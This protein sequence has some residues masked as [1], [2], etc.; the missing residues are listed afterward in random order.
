MF[1]EARKHP[2]IEWGFTRFNRWFLKKHFESIRVASPPEVASRNVLF[3]INHSSWWDPLVIFHL[4]ERLVQSDAYGMMGE[5]GIRRFPFFRSIGA[6]SVDKTDRRHLL[7][8]LKYSIRLLERQ[9]TVWIFPQ[10]EE[11]HQEKRPLEFFSGIS[12]IAEKT[13]DVKVVPVSIYYSLEHTRKPNAYIEIGNPLPE[14][15]YLPLNRKQMTNYFEK[16]ATDQLDRLR[17]KVRTEDH[18]TFRNL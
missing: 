5:E 17:E 12:Y 9:R 7:E 11:Q 8:S 2:L 14:N 3:L 13:P 15:E 1:R 6:F 4:N 16:C 18:R 10:G